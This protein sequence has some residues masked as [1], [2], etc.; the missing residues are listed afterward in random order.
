VHDRGDGYVSLDAE[1]LPPPTEVPP[2]LG[3]GEELFSCAERGLSMK[4]FT[5]NKAKL[6][7][8][9]FD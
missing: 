7:T 5:E 6:K 4:K 3:T 2:F 9:I 1:L 8:R